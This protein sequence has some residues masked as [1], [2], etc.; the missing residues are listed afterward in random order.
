MVIPSDLVGGTPPSPQIAFANSSPGTRTPKTSD[1]ESC[2]KDMRTN[3]WPFKEPGTPIHSSP[4]WMSVLVLRSYDDV[5][6][7]FRLAAIRQMS[8]TGTSAA[9]DPP[10]SG[11]HVAASKGMRVSLGSC[12]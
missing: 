12:E 7:G 2:R 11:H 10:N 9:Y 5:I 4:I 6:V 3:G 1:W 8:Q